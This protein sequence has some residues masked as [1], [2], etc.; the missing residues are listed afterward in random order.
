[1]ILDLQRRFCF[2][3]IPRTGGRLIT[4]V[5]RP[6]LTT[7]GFYGGGPAR[8]IPARAVPTQL[9]LTIDQFNGLWRFTVY[10]PLAEVKRSFLNVITRDAETVRA[11]GDGWI[12][13][14]RWRE[15]VRV[16]LSDPTEAL[17]HLWHING[18]PDEESA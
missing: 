13:C 3:H 5:L 10:R 9:G 4:H 16:G 18:W 14:P 6:L 8:H 11:N 17:T 15:V 12:L 1:M 2:I 7:D